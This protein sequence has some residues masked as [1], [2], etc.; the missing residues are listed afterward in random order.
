KAVAAFIEPPTKGAG[1]LE[2]VR[3]FFR[4]INPVETAYITARIVINV[5]EE[6]TSLQSVAITLGKALVDHVEYLRFKKENPN[7]LRFLEQDLNRRGEHPERR[8][9]VLLGIKRKIGIK[10]L[11]I[12][13][14]ERFLIGL[15]AIELFIQST[16]LIKKERSSYG[17]S[18]SPYIIRATDELR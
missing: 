10:D 8:R 5:I 15:K 1:R 13:T 12:E 7:Y 9:R 16:G 14:K 6:E 17:P 18:G 4:Q 11:E 3:R 2:T